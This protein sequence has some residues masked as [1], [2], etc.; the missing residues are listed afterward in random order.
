MDEHSGFVNLSQNAEAVSEN[1]NT[2]LGWVHTRSIVCAC[3][4]FTELLHRS[5]MFISTPIT[6]LQQR[7]SC[8]HSHF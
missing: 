8:L 5:Y 2:P 4:C 7:S 1:L 6:F 3:V